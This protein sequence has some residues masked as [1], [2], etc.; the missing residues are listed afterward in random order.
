MLERKIFKNSNLI[1]VYTIISIILTGFFIGYENMKFSST[2]WLFIGNDMSAHQTGWFF[3]KNDV[4]RFPIGSNPNFGDQIGNSIVYSDSIPLLA[5]IFKFFKFFT[6]DKFQYFGLWFLVCFFLQGILSFKLIDKLTND[7]I[8]SI[9]SSIF[10]LFF[11]IFIYRLTWHPALFAHWI[12]FITIFLILYDGKNNN[13]SW[14]IL[15][16]ITSLIHFYF[17]IINLIIY[18]FIKFNHL[19]RKKISFNKYLSEIFISHISLILLMYIVGY[20]EVRV[21]DTIALGFGVYKLNLLSFFDSTIS[22][23]GLSWSRILPDIFLQRGEEIE[24]FN[25][26]GLGG[27]ILLSVSIFIL[28]TDQK[29]RS[30]LLPKFFGKGIW[31]ILL[32]IFFLSLSNKISA[33]Q[34]N[35]VNIPLNDLLYGALSIVRS[36]G[37]LFWIISYL[38]IIFAICLFAKKFQKKSKYIFTIIL[39]AHIAD[40]SASFSFFNKR[41]D[42]NQQTL[43]DNFWFNEKLKGYKNL[44]TTNPVN[45][46]KHFDKFAYFIE[47]NKIEKTNLVKL[48]RLDRSKAA[49]N[50]YELINKFTEKNLDNN[51]FYIID[52]VGH[53]LTLKEIFKDDDVGFF[54]KD[55]IWVMT[56]GQKNLMTQNDK[57]ELNNTLLQKINFDKKVEIINEKEKFL[58]LGWSHN[59]DNNGAWSEGKRSNLIFNLVDTKNEV[60]FEFEAAP[61]LNKKNKKLEFEIFVNGNFNNNI[62]FNYENNM[63]NKKKVK[64]K[65]KSENLK[66]DVLNIEFKNKNPVSPLEL[67]LSPDSRELGFLLYNFKIS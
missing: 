19:V 66:K 48:A 15:L 34:L 41:L 18:N 42:N 31:F 32:L 55:N 57:Y 24:G 39:M 17:T 1:I 52:G 2:E 61:F 25:F 53:L 44:M 63:E 50:R 38:I 29:L 20:F 59:F 65:I 46:N 12:F 8:L 36:S 51:T 4:W 11:P 28:I 23:I 22:T 6:S 3:F 26:F 67:L 64:F 7:K 45:Y 58:G 54:I 13:R 9:L 60:Y 56:D 30:L 5:I 43:K 14:I 10:F 33:G 27:L 37:R 35:L 21:V 47:N 49:K 16:L 40:V 62:T